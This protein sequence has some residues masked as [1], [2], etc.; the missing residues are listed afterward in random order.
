MDTYKTF[1]YGPIEP[2]ANGLWRVVGTLPLPLPLPRS[3]YIYRLDDGSLL[4]DSVVA[5]KEDGM[6]ALESLGVPSVMVIT[7]PKHTMDAMFYKRRYPNL[8]VY[9]ADDA[10]EKLPDLEFD[11]RPAAG[12]LPHNVRPWTVP[13]LKITETVLQLP[14]DDGSSALLF[15]DLVN[16]NDEHTGFFVRLF[17]APGGGGVARVLKLT[18]IEDTEKVRAFLMDLSKIPSISLIGG[19]HGAVVTEQC[20]AWLANAAAQM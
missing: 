3:M 16:Q 13:G 19:C 9:G 1:P 12:L 17:G 10:Q 11:A 14:L 15:T 18:Q 2:L 6:L 5:M 8:R 7:H 20:N 4:L